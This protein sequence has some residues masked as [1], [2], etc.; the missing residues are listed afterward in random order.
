MSCREQECLTL[1]ERFNEDFKIGA[2]ALDPGALPPAQG[3]EASSGAMELM[4]SALPLHMSYS[5]VQF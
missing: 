1:K 3:G 2:E 4:S 5:S